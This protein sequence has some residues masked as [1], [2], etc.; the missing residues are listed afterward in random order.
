MYL[1]LSGT[2][3]L[4]Y[5]RHPHFADEKHRHGGR[6]GNAS[7]VAESDVSSESL[8]PGLASHYAMQP[9]QLLCLRDAGSF[10]TCGTFGKA[11]GGCILQNMTVLW[12]K[13]WSGEKNTREHV[14]N[15]DKVHSCLN[16]GNS[17]EKTVTMDNLDLQVG[18]LI[19]EFV[20]H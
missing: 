2:F 19:L 5:K 4:G 11:E 20:P 13:Q 8:L 3:W 14:N 16:C 18:L 17:W 12:G 7:R 1:I 10:L 6:P 9:P 15:E